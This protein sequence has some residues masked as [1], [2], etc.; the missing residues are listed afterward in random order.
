M[1]NDEDENI[2]IIFDIIKEF[3]NNNIKFGLD[4]FQKLNESKTNNYRKFI[5]SLKY[6]E[7]YLVNKRPFEE[8]LKKINYY[9]FS[10]S[11]EEELED[12][13]IKEKI[14]Q[15]FQNN[16]SLE[17]QE[18]FKEI[19]YYYTVE[20]INKIIED[21]LN[22]ILINEEILKILKVPYENYKEKKIY[23]SKADSSILFLYF[24]NENSSL[25]INF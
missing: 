20:H 5:K 23:F 21:K 4:L 16:I 18:F 22:V 3:H 25:L 6:E 24:P 9:D 17:F 11:F 15:I 14:K 19:E 7:I 8:L 12:D 13:E 10:K 1:K 2:N